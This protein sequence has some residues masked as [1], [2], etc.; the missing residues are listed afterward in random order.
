MR[1]RGHFR[2]YSSSK[3]SVLFLKTFIRQDR[4]SKRKTNLKIKSKSPFTHPN[5]I[6]I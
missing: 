4:D 2:Y 5:N 1:H 3:D 6:S